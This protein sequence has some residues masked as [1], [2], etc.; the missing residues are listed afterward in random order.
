MADLDPDERLYNAVVGTLEGRDTT[1]FHDA[2]G[3]EM[4]LGS[5]HRKNSG[6]RLRG[7]A[8]SF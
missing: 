5:A 2:G 1:S 3:A 6:V 4:M 7:E 8:V